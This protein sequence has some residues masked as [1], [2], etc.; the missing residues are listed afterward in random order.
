MLYF[1]GWKTMNSNKN[2]SYFFTKK[3][4]RLKQS[5]IS[6]FSIFRKKRHKP[7]NG[8]QKIGLD[9]RKIENRKTRTLGLLLS[10]ANLM[11]FRVF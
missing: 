7:E 1:L 4:F 5:L 3:F 9:F 2:S 8:K 6:K 11:N 10:H